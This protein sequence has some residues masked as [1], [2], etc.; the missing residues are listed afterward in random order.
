MIRV[1]SVYSGVQGWE[2]V[3]GSGWP[4]GRGTLGR[5]PTD[6]QKQV[7]LLSL[8]IR[9]PH[10]GPAKLANVEKCTLLK[11]HL[12]VEGKTTVFL[13]WQTFPSQLSYFSL[14]VH[15]LVQIQVLAGLLVDSPF[16]AHVRSPWERGVFP[17]LPFRPCLLGHLGGLEESGFWKRLSWVHRV[18]SRR[19]RSKGQRE[20]LLLCRI[21]GERLALI[22]SL[23]VSSSSPSHLTHRMAFRPPV[24][25]PFN[26]TL[27]LAK[28]PVTP[29]VCSCWRFHAPA[30]NLHL[31]FWEMGASF[32]FPSLNAPLGN[33]FK[34]AAAGVCMPPFS[35]SE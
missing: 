2:G 20:R 35:L 5:D 4:R 10:L 16:P 23:Q 28:C 19:K 14:I 12:D 27:N 1:G 24:R 30:C 17:D 34:R 6:R 31:C 11:V 13:V 3:A 9:S 22:G 33:L 21:V 8:G 32:P 29:P 26:L 25:E 15:N 7:N 18:R